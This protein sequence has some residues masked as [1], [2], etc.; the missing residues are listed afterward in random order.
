MQHVTTREIVIARYRENISWIQNLPLS[1]KITIYNKGDI[2]PNTLQTLP[3]VTIITIENKGREAETIVYHLLHRYDTVSDFTVFLQASP[4]DHAPELFECLSILH[5]KRSFSEYE[6]YIP[7]TTRYNADFPPPHIT[8][9]RDNRFFRI[10]DMSVYT[11]DYIEHI[12]TLSAQ[13]VSSQWYLQYNMH[14]GTNIM[15]H[16]FDSIGWKDAISPDE[17]IIKCSYAACFGVTKAAILQH[18]RDFYARLYE[19]TFDKPIAPYILERAWLHI[20]DQRFDA[21]KV[22]PEF[23]LHNKVHHTRPPTNIN[24]DIPKPLPQIENKS[25]PRTPAIRNTNRTIPRFFLFR[26]NK[27]RA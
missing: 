8:E 16:F 23:A 2:L 15:K 5:D 4:F 14:T 27:K 20:F 13:W 21:S 25:N 17:L 12:D 1:W 22:L 24:N 6:N 3:N 26:N 7:V 19:K 18:S 10:E 9:Q 11:L